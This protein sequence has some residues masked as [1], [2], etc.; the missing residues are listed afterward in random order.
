MRAAGI[1]N[2]RVVVV[3]NLAKSEHRNFAS[4]A[5]LMSQDTATPHKKRQAQKRFEFATLSRVEWLD[6]RARLL[7]I[8][9]ETDE[10]PGY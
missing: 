2:P 7:R 3:R 5:A 10:Y 9:G 4:F 6:E 8:Q 1:R